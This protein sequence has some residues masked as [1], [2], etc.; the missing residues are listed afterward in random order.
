MKRN[1]KNRID[2]KQLKQFFSKKKNIM[3]YLRNKNK[4]KLNTEDEIRLSYELQAGSYLSALENKEFFK[5]NEKYCS[6][7]S[8]IFSQYKPS[9]IL[10]VGTS[11][12]KSICSIIKNMKKKPED[13]YGL[14]I[15]LSSLM[16]AKKYS[17]NVKPKINF[18]LGSA[19]NIPFKDNSFD[20]VF[21]IQTIASNIGNE[22]KIIK[23]LV[24]VA[25]KIVI[26]NQP[27]YNPKNKKLT[28]HMEKHAF[29]KDIMNTIK[30]M[31]LNILDNFFLKNDLSTVNKTSVVIINKNSS[32]KE[33]PIGYCSPKSKNFLKKINNHFYCE[34]E[35]RLY[36]VIN[37]IPCLESDSN[38]LCAR[39]PEVSK[40]KGIKIN[41]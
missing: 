32:S 28:A 21:T 8:K 25:K 9:S 37:G 40:F 2:I 26:I 4:K 1:S 30:K 22:R 5:K 16:F 10:H 38:F 29:S 31:K 24:R 3:M 18:F 41:K 14:D 17:E 7:F 23:E 15:S 36:P 19:L 6:E 20:I 11:N 35:G 34:E 27:L 13:V 39:Y 33:N 12:G